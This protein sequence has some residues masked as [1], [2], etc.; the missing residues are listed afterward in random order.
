MDSP[1]RE[2]KCPLISI[3]SNKYDS[4]DGYF[5]PRW[6]EL[7]KRWF[8]KNTGLPVVYVDRQDW[9]YLLTMKKTIRL[10]ESD[11]IKLVQKIV[12]EQELDD[13]D[14]E[15]VFEEHM[16]TLDHI[17]NH[18]NQN[19]TEE[20]LDFMINQ[21]EYEVESAIRGD[22]LTDDQLDELTTYADFLVD[23]LVSEFRLGSGLN[24]GTKAKKT[25]AIRSRRSGIKTATQIKKNSE[26]LRNLSS[27]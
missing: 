11:L 6:Q 9:Y 25:K 7:F 1:I 13:D 15:N 2:D 19:T 17:A 14:T 3:D 27:K 24:E 21:I 23:E 16:M 20:E 10:T 18:F 8:T 22:E 26:V 4:L 5:G 12:K